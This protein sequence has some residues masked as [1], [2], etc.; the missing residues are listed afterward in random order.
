M[1]GY[2]IH[3]DN[4]WGHNIIM[5]VTIVKN[6]HGHWGGE[7]N[8]REIMLDTETWVHTRIVIIKKQNSIL[9]FNF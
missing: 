2:V 4:H 5:M 9:K 7:L 1:H 8:F 3:I 6:T